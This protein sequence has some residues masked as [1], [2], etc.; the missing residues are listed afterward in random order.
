M[1]DITKRLLE[2]KSVHLNQEQTDKLVERL[3]RDVIGVTQQDIHFHQ[4]YLYKT[5]EREFTAREFDDMTSRF[6]LTFG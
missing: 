2:G 6:E 5:R 1:D 4:E 3:M